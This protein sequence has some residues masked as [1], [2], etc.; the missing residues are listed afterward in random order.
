M[1]SQLK[2]IPL[3]RALARRTRRQRT[4]VRAAWRRIATWA[5]GVRGGG[6]DALGVG[7]AAGS[8]A[9]ASAV[10]G[11]D[12][13]LSRV[14]WRDQGATDHLVDRAQAMTRNS[15]AWRLV[16]APMWAVYAGV[17]LE[18]GDRATAERLVRTYFSRGLPA[19]VL[20]R[21]LPVA[22]FAHDLGLGG[23]AVARSAHV[24][25]LMAANSR[26]RLFAELVEG[27]S[28]AV[29]GNGPGNLGTGLGAEIDAHDI[30]I[31]FNNHPAGYEADYGSRTDIWVRGAHRDVADRTA[32]DA[33][34]LVV[35]E[36]D[37]FRGVLEVP[38]HADI[39]YRDALLSPDRLT[40]IDTGGKRQLRERSGL[41]LPTSGAQV[42]FLL[43]EVLGSLE[44]VDVY[45]FSTITGGDRGHYF[46]ERGDMGERHDA[47][48]EGAF[49]RSLLGPRAGAAASAPASGG[50]TA[51]RGAD[52]A[53]APDDLAGADDDDPGPTVF[54]C[55]F[56]EYD[57]AT[58]RTGGPGGV[59][60]TQ[61]LALGTERSGVR[62]EYAFQTADAPRLRTELAPAT[63]GLSTK[64]A[65]IVVGSEFV[66]RH[67]G[68]ARARQRGDVLLV[69]HE[70]GSAYGAYRLG[71]PYVIVYHQQGSTLQ[72][73]RSV[74]RVPTPHETRVAGALEKLVCDNADAVYFPSLGARDTYLATSDSG[75]RGDN[76]ASWAL[77][78]T[79][80]AVDHDADTAAREHLLAELVAELDLPPRTPET[81]VFISV[82]DFNSDKGLDRVPA[83]LSRHARMSGRTVVWIAI[84][85]TGDRAR[86][87]R[88]VA[89]QRSW[90][91]TARL[92]GE[93]TT[94]DRLLAL[95]DYADYY[96]MMHRNAIFDLATLEAM[97]AGKPLI[98]SPVGG[99]LE[100]D[101]DGNV[102][103]VD[104]D[105]ILDACRVLET[106]DRRMWGE[107]NR[108]VFEAHFSLGRFAERYG[109]MLDEHLARVG[110]GATIESAR[111]TPVLAAAGGGAA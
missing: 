84:G 32:L 27:R 15:A 6:A 37:V 10:L 61:Q 36:M 55:A 23:D 67:D 78:N 54:S 80:S 82:G 29:V 7:A 103:F 44:N 21:C 14:E 85:A 19:D 97:R 8:P 31:R 90:P 92:I 20:A 99:N 30:V 104:E 4:A 52:E 111:R 65:E 56:R 35:W 75:V 100:V 51:L 108:A 49:L 3:V 33:G 34:R 48:Q 83:L 40:H 16:P 25:E 95:L 38:A 94:H 1:K 42:L 28:I 17:L 60:A 76:F 73:M 107:R 64:I 26:R 72:E 59:L 13:T 71:V 96:V 22:R 53:G 86:F 109:R 12:Y 91:F 79:V 58:G 74:G 88:L 62:L 102:L 68:I 47:E 110:G 46:D 106:R 9:A 43:H 69:C 45:G 63:A 105:T 98:L 70:L 41:L 101:L 39:L 87:D 50:S 89:Q 77:Y 11:A 93:R 57:P 5:A 2:K 24:A 66:R 81:D 18:A